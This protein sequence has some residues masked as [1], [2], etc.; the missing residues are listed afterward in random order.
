MGPVS[1]P[2]REGLLEG[3][4]DRWYRPREVARQLGV[5]DSTLRTYAAHFAPLLSAPARPDASYDGRGFRHRRY[6]EADLVTLRA[7][8]ELL[9]A[10]MSYEAILDRLGGNGGSRPSTR[11]RRR[12]AR[13]RHP[14]DVPPPATPEAPPAPAEPEERFAA[15]PPGL[16]VDDVRG[17][18]GDALAEV[19][20]AALRAT[21]AERG[22]DSEKLDLLARQLR[23]IQSRLDHLEELLLTPAPDPSRAGWFARL[24]GRG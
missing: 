17:A 2:T 15:P 10:G 22:R 5:P 19:I 6:A 8:K 16:S 20:P 3:S 12:P 11:P 14:T 21:L 1:W 13:A 7:A 18:I 23:E 24:R 9:D 4:S